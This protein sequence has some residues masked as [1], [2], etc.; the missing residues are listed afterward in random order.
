MPRVGRPGQLV[1]RDLKVHL[2]RRVLRGEKNRKGQ[3]GDPGITGP[4]GVPGERGIKGDPGQQGEKGPPG[5][6]GQESAHLVGDGKRVEHA[7]SV[8][9]WNPREGHVSGNITFRRHQGALMIGRAGTYYVYSQM[10]YED[11][12]SYSMSHYTLLN[13]RKILGSQSSVN[14][15]DAR[16]FTNYQGGVFKLNAGDQLK[17]EVHMSKTYYMIKEFSYFGLFMLYPG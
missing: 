1:P 3:K 9:R 12:T 10:Y 15:C 13:G 11:C 8:D 4:Q 6:L 5:S 17:V 7:G 14:H 2:D 16:Y